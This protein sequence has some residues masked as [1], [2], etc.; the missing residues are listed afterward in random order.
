MSAYTLITNIDFVTLVGKQLRMNCHALLISEKDKSPNAISFG[1]SNTLRGFGLDPGWDVFQYWL[2]DDA[3]PWELKSAQDNSK[4]FM[5]GKGKTQKITPLFSGQILKFK[6]GEE[7]FIQVHN[8]KFQIDVLETDAFIS[9]V[10]KELIIRTDKYWDRPF[11][12]YVVNN[13]PHIM[14]YLQGRMR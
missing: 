3:L 6:T 8:S 10:W 4:V 1:N 12:P 13:R 7:F 2:S 11:R 14:E 9:D 5:S